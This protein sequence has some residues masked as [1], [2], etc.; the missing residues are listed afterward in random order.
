VGWT[1][2]VEFQFYV[3]FPFLL[4]FVD[5]YGIK[6]LFGLILLAVSLRWGGWYTQNTVQKLAYWTIFGRIDQFLMGMVGCELFFR[7]PRIIG[8]LPI[9]L[10]LVAAWLV[11]CHRF[12]ATG[13][14]YDN[15]AY[16]SP[17][18]I[19]IYLPTLEGA[20]YALIIT[21]CSGLRP[22]NIHF[23]SPNYLRISAPFDPN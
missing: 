11:L 4:S 9:L 7:Y 10:L 17:S 12:N 6:Y 15:P 14:F 16:P 13:G 5:K 23:F 2:I 19:W 8:R 18:S 3:I 21:S 1:I 22:A 20:F